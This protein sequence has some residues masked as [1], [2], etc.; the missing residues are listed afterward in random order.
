MNGAWDAPYACFFNKV[1]GQEKDFA[2]PTQTTTF[3]G[4]HVGAILYGCPNEYQHDGPI[5]G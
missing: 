5:M 2:H 1:G 3:K 4:R